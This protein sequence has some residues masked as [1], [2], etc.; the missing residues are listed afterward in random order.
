MCVFVA[1]APGSCQ[2]ECWPR[3]SWTNS[4]YAWGGE[5]PN[6]LHMQLWVTGRDV[7]ILHQIAR[8]TPYQT[9]RSG[10][11]WHVR[12]YIC[13]HVT[14]V[15]MLPWFTRYHGSHITMV[16]T[17][18]WFT[19]SHGSHAPMGG[20]LRAGGSLTTGTVTATAPEYLTWASEVHDAHTSVFM[21]MWGTCSTH[22]NRGIVVALP[23]K[24]SLYTYMYTKMFVYFQHEQMRT[25]PFVWSCSVGIVV[26]PCSL[27]FSP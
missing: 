22:G 25:L 26:S 6:Q 27:H 23:Y 10:H 20:G 24:G 17:L 13:S 7:S 1:C 19:C 9:V 11:I 21:W 5:Q 16:H 8:M 2:V 15:H 14:M 12:M 4:G 3:R 18:P